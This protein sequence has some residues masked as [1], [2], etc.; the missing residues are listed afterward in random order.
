MNWK[1]LE[2]RTGYDKA[3]FYAR[4]GMFFAEKQYKKEMPYLIN[5]DEKEWCLFYA[6][7]HLA[8]FYAH[9]QKDSFVAVS[10]F[11]VTE[12]YRR[13]GLS[14]YMLTDI[15][16]NF[17]CVRI[18]TCSQHLLKLL[19]KYHFFRVSS[20]GSYLTLEWNKEEIA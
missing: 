17:S 15:T 8:G 14:E 18:T 12:P 6:D 7:D 19:N 9:E 20:R 2:F 4:T 16:Q 10:G 3:D 13:M 11:Y 1:K 5:T